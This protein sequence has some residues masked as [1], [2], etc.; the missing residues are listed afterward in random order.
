MKYIEELKHGN[1]FQHNN[2]FFIITSDFRQIKG[3]T[4]HRCISLKNG[5]SIWMNS[6]DIIDQPSIFFQ[7]SENNLKEL[8]YE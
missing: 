3:K 2:S 6:N 8:N 7:D 5:N 4:Q 1:I